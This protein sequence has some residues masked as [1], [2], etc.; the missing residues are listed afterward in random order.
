MAPRNSALMGNPEAA[1]ITESM[2][3]SGHIAV[4]RPSS[5]PASI[6]SETRDGWEHGE[7]VEAAAYLAALDL[8]AMVGRTLVSA[9]VGN[10][11]SCSGFILPQDSTQ[12][13]ASCARPAR[14]TCAAP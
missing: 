5:S 2:P 7:T 6:H 10:R 13:N 1:P 12:P 8:V 4:V 3:H 11:P 14:P 9:H